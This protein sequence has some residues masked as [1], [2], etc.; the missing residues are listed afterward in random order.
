MRKNKEQQQGE[1]DRIR[2]LATDNTNWILHFSKACKAVTARKNSLD[3]WSICVCHDGTLTSKEK[4]Q[5]AVQLGG[6]PLMFEVV[7]SQ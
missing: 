3:D 6:F 2:K 4:R 5:L 1:F 7:Q